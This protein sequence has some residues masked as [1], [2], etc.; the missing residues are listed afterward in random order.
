MNTA[1][2]IVPLPKG[3]TRASVRRVTRHILALETGHPLP[4]FRHRPGSLRDQMSRLF[5][6][7]SVATGSPDDKSCLLHSWNQQAMAYSIAKELKI[8]ITTY[9]EN[10]VGIRV[11]RTR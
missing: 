9:K 10:G 2:N 5:A 11:W 1:E 7:L 3:G 8:K 6:Q 4:A